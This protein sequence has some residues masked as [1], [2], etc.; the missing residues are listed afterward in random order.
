MIV[1]HLFE[2]GSGPFGRLKSSRNAAAA[3]WVTVT[4]N[5]QLSLFPEA[6]MATHFTGVVPTGNADPEAGLQTTLHPGQL[7]EEVTT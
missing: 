6:S 7:S 1:A 2:P 4:E 3:Y 5:E